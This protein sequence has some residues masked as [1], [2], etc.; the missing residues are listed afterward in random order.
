MYDDNVVY[1]YIVQY[2]IQVHCTGT[3]ITYKKMLQV[4]SSVVLLHAEKQSVDG[5][6]HK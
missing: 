6:R 3:H 2:T 4:I 1:R 5:K